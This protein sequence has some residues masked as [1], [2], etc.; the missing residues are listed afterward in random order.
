MAIVIFLVG[1]HS[2][3]RCV[4]EDGQ[5]GCGAQNDDHAARY[6]IH[7]QQVSGTELAAQEADT[8]GEKKPP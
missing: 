6:A 3:D 4:Y 7:P 1:E 8:K 5:Y 2:I